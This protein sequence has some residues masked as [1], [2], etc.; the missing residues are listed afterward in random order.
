MASIFIDINMSLYQ[1]VENL[2]FSSQ[3]EKL[4]IMDGRTNMKLQT[5]KRNKS[6]FDQFYQSQKGENKNKRTNK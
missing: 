4:K 3:A 6:T 1:A 5:Q 2:N